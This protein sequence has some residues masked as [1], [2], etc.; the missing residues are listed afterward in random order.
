MRLNLNHARAIPLFGGLVDCTWRDH[1][2]S[3]TQTFVI[4]LLSTTPIWLGALIVVYSAGAGLEL[5]A[6]G[7]ALKSTV[8][9]GELLMYS[10]ALLAP[11]FWMALVD[12]PGAHVFPSKVSHM[13]LIGVIDLVAGAFFGLVTA[14]N[15]ANPRFISTLSTW[16]FIASLVLLYLGTVYHTSRLP[17]APQEFKRQEDDFSTAYGEHRQ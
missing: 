8:K 4:V 3:L 9:N 7:T 11:V 14:H 16:M 12:P 15:N 5:A 10:T 6:F 1:W 2:D 17:D 13:V